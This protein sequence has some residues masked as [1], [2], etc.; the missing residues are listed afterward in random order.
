MAY[1]LPFVSAG[2]QKSREKLRLRYD[3]QTDPMFAVDPPTMAP[4]LRAPNPM[5]ADIFGRRGDSMTP[6]APEMIDVFN[7]Q[8]ARPPSPSI[9]VPTPMAQPASQP[10]STIIAGDESAFL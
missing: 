1:T 9:G 5:M 6:M 3:A 2:S 10:D 4:N 8:G 7:T